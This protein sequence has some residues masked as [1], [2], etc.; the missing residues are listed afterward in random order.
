MSPV[1]AVEA[2]VVCKEIEARG[3]FQR[4]NKEAYIS[5]L[6]TV[7]QTISINTRMS[8][9]QRV[10]RL[11]LDKNPSLR[12][13]LCTFVMAFMQGCVSGRS[14]CDIVCS[15]TKYMKARLS[16]SESYCYYLL[17]LSVLW[18]SKLRGWFSSPGALLGL[19]SGYNPLYTTHLG[20]QDPHLYGATHPFLCK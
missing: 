16:P 15:Q 11:W 19:H 18:Y 8:Y 9:V 17:A 3:H 2:I 10:D 1:W 14:C 5:Y 12:H 7:T 13:F 20:T 6:V 4:Q